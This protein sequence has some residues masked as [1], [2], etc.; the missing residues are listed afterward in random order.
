[1]GLDLGCWG[2]GRSG[3]FGH[4]ILGRPRSTGLLDGGELLGLGRN[5]FL[6]SLLAFVRRLLGVHAIVW[7]SSW[8][9]ECAEL[10]NFSSSEV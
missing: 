3:S 7:I 8:F 5:F 10:E 1:M 6:F 2:S 4:W 9:E